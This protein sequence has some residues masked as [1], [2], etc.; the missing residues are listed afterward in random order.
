[1]G[2]WCGVDEARDNGG[3]GCDLSPVGKT[4][5]RVKGKCWSLVLTLIAAYG[6]IEET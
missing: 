4:R 2:L 3:C 1:M 5:G 6:G